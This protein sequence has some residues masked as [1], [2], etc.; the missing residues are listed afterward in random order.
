MAN[1]EG[2]PGN[3]GNPNPV[4]TEEFK[5]KRSETQYGG[6]RP[7]A[8]VH[9]TKAKPKMYRRALEWLALQEPKEGEDP[10]DFLR[11]MRRRAPGHIP[12]MAMILTA[13]VMEKLLSK[14]T[15]ELFDRIIDQTE[16]KQ[17][18]PTQELPPPTQLPEDCASE[19]E[20]AAAH[21]QYARP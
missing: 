5:Q 10:M 7:N 1:P 21:A 12:N 6:A 20:A 4:Q 14:P 18:Q 2:N 11:R 15:G 8:P 9:L 16:G 17:V 13:R 19:E 3:A